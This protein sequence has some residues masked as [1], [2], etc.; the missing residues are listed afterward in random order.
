VHAG[1]SGSATV[2]VANAPWRG[3]SC[4]LLSYGWSRLVVGFVFFFGCYFV[5]SHLGGG[6]FIVQL[7]LSPV[8]SAN[9]PLLIRHDWVAAAT[10]KTEKTWRK[11]E[12]AAAA[13][14]EI[15]EKLSQLPFVPF[16]SI[17]SCISVPFPPRSPFRCHVPFPLHSDPFPLCG[18]H[19]SPLLNANNALDTR[20]NV[21]FEREFQCS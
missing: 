11:T 4:S 14:R 17:P 1:E 12:S 13:W 19:V 9:V 20:W 16:P 10:E 8:R 7:Q 2:A 5:V 18:P 15:S 21:I 6:G 3:Q